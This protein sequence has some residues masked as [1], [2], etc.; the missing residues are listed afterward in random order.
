MFCSQWQLS[1]LSVLLLFVAPLSEWN[2]KVRDV[3]LPGLDCNPVLNAGYENRLQLEDSL[4]TF[5]Q[6]L[7]QADHVV[8]V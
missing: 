2:T 5:T 3:Y 8:M 1:C 4:C 6:K 7:E